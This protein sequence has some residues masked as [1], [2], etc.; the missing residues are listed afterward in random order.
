M[1]VLIYAYDYIYKVRDNN[2]LKVLFSA[3][4]R[5]LMLCFDY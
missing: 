2:V 1:N 5:Y 3:I 4:F